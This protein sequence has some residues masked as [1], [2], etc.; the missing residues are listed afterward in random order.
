MNA[1][2]V[3]LLQ[4]LG[5]DSW[6][7]CSHRAEMS[8]VGSSRWK[9]PRWAQR[10]SCECSCLGRRPQRSKLPPPAP[11][12]RGSDP[13]E[14]SYLSKRQTL[15][16]SHAFKRVTAHFFNLISL[17]TS[18][19]PGNVGLDKQR[20]PEAS[21]YSKQD[22]GGKLNQVPRCVKLHIEQHQA[23]VSKGIDGAQGE[24]CHQG[25]KE[26]APQGFQREVITYLMESKEQKKISTRLF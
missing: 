25:S 18:L 13:D 10:R 12:W 1:F 8:R 7:V 26:R 20:P 22:K 5:S 6:P 23:A 16:F 9:A 2:S 21:K 19:A 3:P 4:T 24:G 11:Q 17:L 15:T 14:W